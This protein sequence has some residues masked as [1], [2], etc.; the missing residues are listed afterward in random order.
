[1]KEW[2]GKS[3]EIKTFI[4]VDTISK[5]LNKE[6]LENKEVKL[7]SRWQAATKLGINTMA[8]VEE[9]HNKHY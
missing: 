3:R 9:Q 8:D 2:N 6:R 7:K 4:K 5:R 1:M